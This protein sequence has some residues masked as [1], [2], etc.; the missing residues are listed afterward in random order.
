M[1]GKKS[2]QPTTVPRQ[3]RERHGEPARRRSSSAT[4]RSASP[5]SISRRRRP[6]VTVTRS[7]DQAKSAGSSTASVRH[8]TVVE[9]PVRPDTETVKSQRYGTTIGRE[10][11]TSTA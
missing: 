6:S 10:P 3:R 4:V 5:I 11:S 1:V 2:V 9:A 8:N 7:T